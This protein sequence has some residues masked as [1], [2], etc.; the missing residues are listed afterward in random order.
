[1]GL[2]RREEE[3]H[4][5]EEAAALL[6]AQVQRVVE[7]P[8]VRDQHRHRHVIRDVGAAQHLG[9]IGEL[10][11]HVRAHEARHLEPAQPGPREHLDE[12]DLVVRGDHLWLVLKPVA[13]AYLA[14]SDHHG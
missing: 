8:L 11:D 7:A 14:D 5:L 13:R 1:V 4:L 2:R 6:L 10:R 3:V 12:P 9:A